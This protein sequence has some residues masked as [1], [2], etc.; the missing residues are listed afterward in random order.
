[1]CPVYYVNDV[2]GLHPL[3]ILPF[4]RRNGG[5]DGATEN[6]WPHPHPRCP[7]AAALALPL[8]GEAEQ[9]DYVGSFKTYRA[10]IFRWTSLLPP[11]M[12]PGRE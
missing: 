11:K 5:G 10:R 2:T 6:R 3:L 8:E 9:C 4:R 1:M 12:V 7:L